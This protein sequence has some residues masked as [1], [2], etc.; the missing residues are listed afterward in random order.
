M[1]MNL[2]L[3]EDI[4]VGNDNAFECTDTDDEKENIMNICC[5]R[6]K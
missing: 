1:K 5:G 6:K 2:F 3:N 4:L